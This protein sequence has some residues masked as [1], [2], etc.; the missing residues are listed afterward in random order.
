MKVM[1]VVGTRPNFIKAVSL[2]RAMQAD[3]RFELVLVHT[4]QHYDNQMSDVFFRELELPQPHVFLGVGPGTHTETTARVMLA[5]EPQ[6]KAHRPELVIV[7]GDVNSTLA[8]SLAASQQQVRL[9]HVEA[10]LRSFDRAMPEEFNRIITDALSDYLFTPSA[11]ADENLRREGIASGKIFLVGNVM[12]DALR[13]FQ[14]RALACEA[15]RKFN[16]APKQYTLLTLHRPSNVDS[17]TVLC[18]LMRTMQEIAQTQP[19][20]FSVH[21]RTYARLRDLGLLRAD[22]HNGIIVSEPLGYLEFLSVMSQARV[23]LT[24]SGGIQE[25]TTVLGIPCLTLRENTERPVTITCGTNR[26]VGMA[27]ENILA[28]FAEVMSHN[29]ATP[30]IPPL[31]DGHAAE[32]IVEILHRAN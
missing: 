17:K 1:L 6:I 5:L 15:W 9:A 29:G 25:E 4:G 24:D 27:R 20:L 23:V 7:V 12:I 2:V 10:G 28:G 13:H 21:P 18:E 30:R 22:A 8:A 26:L 14:T 32:R 19:V 11:D 31:W 3:G 16:L